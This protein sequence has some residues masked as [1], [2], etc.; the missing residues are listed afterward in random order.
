M[1]ATCSL[2]CSARSAGVLGKVANWSRARLSCSSGL[3]QR[4]AFQRPLSRLA[5]QARCLLDQAGFGAVTRHQFGL[6]LGNLGE[7]AFEGFGDASVKRA[8]RLA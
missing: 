4:R 6:V 7:L 2:T 5:P 3:N 1:S 8:S